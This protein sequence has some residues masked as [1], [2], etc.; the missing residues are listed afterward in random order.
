VREK[1][2]EKEMGDS[3]ACI[4]SLSHTHHLSPSHIHLPLSLTIPLSLTPSLSLSGVFSGVFAAATS[5]I[6]SSSLSLSPLSS[7]STHHRAQLAGISKL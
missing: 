2:R 1:K 7:S 5:L 4:C 6:P 3:H